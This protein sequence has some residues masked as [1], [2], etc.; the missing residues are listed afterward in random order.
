MRRHTF[1]WLTLVWL[2]AASVIA[3][4]KQELHQ[5]KVGPYGDQVRIIDAMIR[6]PS[7][8][9]CPDSRR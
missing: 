8:S 2:G 3:L 5:V 4:G 6:L 7:R 1:N 9:V